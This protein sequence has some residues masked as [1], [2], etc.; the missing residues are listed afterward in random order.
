MPAITKDSGTLANGTSTPAAPAE[1]DIAYLDAQRLTLADVSDTVLYD[2][3]YE[4]GTQA[5]GYMVALENGARRHGDDRSA[6][7]WAERRRVMMDERDEVRP[8]DRGAQIAFKIKWDRMGREMSR[9]LQEGT[10]LIPT[11]LD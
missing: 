10:T 4:S 6:Q 1:V 3:F 5:G 9:T 8:F 7:L 11:E 2:I